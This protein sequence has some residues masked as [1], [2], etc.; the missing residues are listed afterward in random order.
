[1]IV[2]NQQENNT[3]EVLENENAPI[4]NN[5]VVSEGNSVSDK[6]TDPDPPI[7]KQKAFEYFKS[8]LDSNNKKYDESTL[9]AYSSNKNLKQTIRKFYAFNGL[10]NQMPTETE[11]D[12]IYNSWI[13]KKLVEKKNLSQTLNQEFSESPNMEGSSGSVLTSENT[14]SSSDLDTKPENQNAGVITLDDED[15]NNAGY[16]FGKEMP[17]YDFNEWKAE[18]NIKGVGGYIDEK[19][20]LSEIVKSI[21]KDLFASSE[22]DAKQGLETILRP[23]G[24]T[25][26]ETSFAADKLLITSPQG[27]SME[28]RLFTD[29]ILGYQ[30]RLESS[31]QTEE[32]VEQLMDKRFTQ[33]KDFITESGSPIDHM[34]NVFS[35]SSNLV[36]DIE[37]QSKNSLQPSQEKLQFLAVASGVS[38]NDFFDAG[39]F[40]PKRVEATIKKIKETLI[41]RKTQADRSDYFIEQTTVKR[42]VLSSTSG[43]ADI[44]RVLGATNDEKEITNANVVQ[45]TIKELDN[46]LREIKLKR[47]SAS[48]LIG[49]AMAI[50][51]SY[52]NIDL[53]N[54]ELL[55]KVAEAGLKLSDLPTE[56]IKI[57][58]VASTMN[59]LQEILMNPAG[60]NSVI[61]GKIDIEIGDPQDY[62]ALS[63]YIKGAQA[64]VERNEATPTETR[65]G[66]EAKIAYEFTED[67][68]QGVGLGFAD[69]LA[70][71][72]AT[73]SDVLQLAGVTEST[74]DGIVYGKFGLPMTPFIDPK[75]VLA[76][77]ESSLPLYNVSIS[78]AGSF[79]DML[80]LANEPV[81]SS[82]P[83]YAAFSVNPAFGLA[84]TGVSAYGATLEELD[85]LKSAAQQS[86]KNGETLTETQKNIL[87]T[88][89]MKARG[90]AL[91]QAGSE[92]LI[93]RLFTYNFFKSMSGVRNFKGARTVGNSRKLAE[94]YS[95]IVNKN[96]RQ[97][98]S[99]FLGV[100]Y[101]VL[102]REIPEEELVALNKYFIDVQ[103]G[104]DDWDDDRA[105]KLMK[106]TG[107]I[108]FFS[109]SSMSK[110]GRIRQ[111]SQ[112]KKISDNVIKNNINI[113]GELDLAKAKILLDAE[114]SS[115]EKRNKDGE[116][117]PELDAAKSLQLEINDNINLN[118]KRKD[119]LL[120]RMT[121]DDKQFF[122]ETITKFEEARRKINYSLIDE[123]LYNQPI[124]NDVRKKVLSNME[125]YR[126]DLR[127][128]LTKYPSEL[129]Y[130]FVSDETK[131]KYDEMASKFL[132]DEAKSNGVVNIELKT[133][134][135]EKKAS[136]LY[137]DDLKN[138]KIKNQEKFL[139]A[140][141]YTYAD[142]SAVFVDINERDFERIINEKPLIETIVQARNVLYKR[143]SIENIN[144]LI[145]ADVDIKTD[146]PKNEAEVLIDRIET[147]SVD[148]ELL[149]IL[150]KEQ[151]KIIVK[152][153]AD[154]QNNK[155]P[156]LGQVESVLN[157]HEIATSIN[158]K[159]SEKIDIFSDNVTD[160][161]S[162][163][164]SLSQKY[165][166]VK[167]G[168]GTGDILLKTLFRNSEQGAEFYDLY[169]EMIRK[170][171]VAENKTSKDYDRMLKKYKESVKKYNKTVPLIQKVS[172]VN[173]NEA[174]NSYELY[175]LAGALRQSGVK[176]DAGVDLE[177]AR[178]KSLLEQELKLRKSDLDGATVFNKQKF[179]KRYSYWKTAYDNLG[180]KNARRFEDISAKA[181]KFNVDFVNELATLQPGESALKR[182]T[183]FGGSIENKKRGTKKPFVDGTYV[184]VPFTKQA[185]NNNTFTETVFNDIK[186]FLKGKTID[187]ASNLTEISFVE[188][189]SNDGVRL[190]PGMFAKNAFTKM[191]GA[192]MDI[193][194][195]QDMVTIQ[196]L[197]QNETFKSIFKN[198]SD[199]NL[200]ASYFQKQNDQ[201]NKVV[202]GGDGV[203]VDVG[204]DDYKTTL[205]KASKAGFSTIAAVS[206]AR[207]SQRSTQFTSAVAGT[208][209]Y[210][211]SKTANK[212][213]AKGAS[214]F[215]VGLSSSFN[216]A[217]S[218]TKLGKVIQDNLSKT[219]NLSNL[220]SKSRTGMRNS[221]KAEFGLGDNTNVDS[222]YILDFLNI[223]DKDGKIIKS[224]GVKTTVN[225]FLDFV[226]DGSE[227]S[228]D[229][230]L[231]TADQSAA[232][233]AF[234]AHYIQE[235]E[236]QG[237]NFDDVKSMKEW[238]KN[239]N[240]KPN[241]D[242]INKADAMVAQTMRQSGD[243]GEALLFDGSSSKQT[244]VRS[245]FP[246]QKFISNARAN[247]ANQYAI[248]KDPTIPESQKKEA[249]SAIQGLVQEVGSFQFIKQA[250]ALSQLKGFAAGIL[251]FGLEDEDIKR[252]GGYSQ[253][254]GA[255]LLP[256]EDRPGVL[257]QFDSSKNLYDDLFDVNLTIEQKKTKESEF[258]AAIMNQKGV[259]LDKASL[260]IDMFAKEY[261]KKFKAGKS[262]DLLIPTI[263]D[264][265]TSLGPIAFTEGSDDALF[266]G[267]NTFLEDDVFREFISKDLEK[268]DTK[269]G[270][271]NLIFQQLSGI[272][273]I[274]FEQA[275][276]FVEAIYLKSEH[277]RKESAGE[278]GTIESKI[279]GGKSILKS[280]KIDKSIEYLFNIRLMNLVVP[281][282]PKGDLNKLGNYLERALQKEFTVKYDRNV[283][284]NEDEKTFSD[285]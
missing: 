90:I 153:F 100:D 8:V 70:N 147:L 16:T 23:Y 235:R 99:N 222:S 133:E 195:R 204:S 216:G 72:G 178:W 29:G 39:S 182:I 167:F 276:K 226:S 168:F 77:K 165:N 61:R 65:V 268:A 151:S 171:N 210:I 78:D 124:R 224:L 47:K 113:P 76:M 285:N 69:I 19:K 27:S 161:K 13:D 209:P 6:K 54:P 87:N 145:N 237:V 152:F 193:E 160:P 234:E 260:Y 15:L 244:L 95:K 197:L 201:F 282:I 200:V 213:L 251:G 116:V 108:S 174:D 140:E 111:T 45:N 208:R 130:N 233:L 207:V 239:E 89:D 34:S 230:F 157:A 188:N 14:A 192:Q 212:H 211:K 11:A 247:F 1:M 121:K 202:N 270:K 225:N 198:Q 18:I 117:D 109:A 93:T 97:K 131:I 126:N 249:R 150:P 26:S 149:R 139:P 12:S 175:M 120:K 73:I 7:N 148:T 278:Y 179:E 128:M 273:G 48:K 112:I 138:N 3:V 275:N 20:Y 135:I 154:I 274:G 38:V 238:W 106:D 240:A 265:F 215:I 9:R 241:I 262:Y 181:K 59:T 51:G 236:R 74:A 94:N 252:Y 85:Q 82:I 102:K 125:T 127:A 176:N 137:L 283:S 277:I 41:A 255:D 50:S 101:A 31:G 118:D 2:N 231:G 64:L 158:S 189:L 164:N 166:T 253:L 21:P 122:L 35:N 75:E 261:E 177:F 91:S 254:L 110:I 24:F 134:Q 248:L 81:A 114:I 33:L 264:T 214:K 66:A 49:S 105:I 44:N 221:L 28:V 279:G 62:G 143:N 184:P 71:T 223:E 42:D 169:R 199:Y 229:L 136:E 83:Y 68:V 250:F 57:N 246:F 217:E 43:K 272:Y 263:Q 183:D 30:G 55:N 98:L 243:L 258:I 180:I 119:D 22:R 63:D 129:S 56:G 266:Y 132:L 242:A 259:T 170:V 60:R 162:F 256:I 123:T 86:L 96:Y 185:G 205:R 107:L 187:D 220:Y 53:F 203:Y 257:E 191:R 232:N 196:Y 141:G 228:L 218:R 144:P 284:K 32:E 88:S 46:I 84:V 17:S 155:N 190:N 172:D 280:E 219:G 92:T 281:G 186:D 142:P 36:I 163:L 115:L 25:V 103:F 80:A 269:E 10:V 267:L 5:V 159:T 104:I 79:G 156:S 146:T 245:L 37:S 271:L 67:L 194:A 52:K 4:N 206:L 173:A 58:G 40:M 227:L